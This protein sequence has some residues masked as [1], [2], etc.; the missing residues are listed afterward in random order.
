MTAILHTDAYCVS[1]Q[2]TICMVN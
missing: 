2:Q 1:L